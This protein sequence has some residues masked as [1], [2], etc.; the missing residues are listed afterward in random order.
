MAKS[1]WFLFII[2]ILIVF[3]VLKVVMKKQ[4]IATKLAF[5]IFIALMLTVGYVYTVSDIEVKSVKDAFNFGGVYFSWLS[6]VFGNVKSITS[7]AIEQNW[8]VINSPGTS[9][10]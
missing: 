6:S 1:V 5:F 7:N 9:Y 10:G 8:D 2:I 3:L 4:A